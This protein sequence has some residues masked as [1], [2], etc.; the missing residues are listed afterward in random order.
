MS[1][2]ADD[3][4]VYVEDPRESTEEWL[5]LTRWFSKGQMQNKHPE[6][7]SLLLYKDVDLSIFYNE[8]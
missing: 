3:V 8:K 6:T 1:L 7:C 5:E 2:F 4:V